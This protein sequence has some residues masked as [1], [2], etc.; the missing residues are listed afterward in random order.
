MSDDWT[1][2]RIEQRV[3]ELKREHDGRA[4]VKAIKALNDEIGPDDR[5]ILHTVLLERAQ[6]TGGLD[7]VERRRYEGGWLKRQVRKIDE[8]L[9][10]HRR[11]EP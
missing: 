5:E 9:D 1:K 2:A 8:S 4:F 10:R 11:D 7:A 6:E 3:D